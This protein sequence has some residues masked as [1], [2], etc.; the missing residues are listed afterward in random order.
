VPGRSYILSR[1]GYQQLL[2][3]EAEKR[4]VQFRFG[5]P[6]VTIQ[7]NAERPALT[8]KNGSRIEADL[9]IGADGTYYPSYEITV[10]NTFRSEILFNRRL[11]VLLCTRSQCVQW[12]GGLS[13][14]L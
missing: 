6:A 5:S 12:V 9:V 3:E 4:G 11:M 1:R 2:F 13:W 14:T 10:K 7:D 8:L